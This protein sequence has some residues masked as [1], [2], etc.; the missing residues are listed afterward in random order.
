MGR[1]NHLGQPCPQNWA[2]WLI[3]VGRAMHIRQRRG[4]ALEG[5]TTE[6]NVSPARG[7][8]ALAFYRRSDVTKFRAMVEDWPL[9]R[10]LR[11][12]IEARA[13]RLSSKSDP[14]RTATKC[15]R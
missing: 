9:K 11:E 10:I 8:L 3:Q 14:A 15:T 6:L 12:L 2:E 4:A 5:I 1:G 7:R 13:F